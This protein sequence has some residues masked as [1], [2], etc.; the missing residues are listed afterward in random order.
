[1]KNYRLRRVVLAAATLQLCSG[2]SLSSAFAQTAPDAGSL[3]HSFE[4]SVPAPPPVTE[5]PETAPAQAVAPKKEG[6][7]VLVKSFIIEAHQFSDEELQG[8][9]AEY[10]GQNLTL[11]ELQQAARKISEY[12]K[13]Q[14][15]LA[16]AYLPPQTIKDGTVKIIVLEG[17]LG[18]IKIDP[19][20]ESRF[21]NDTAKDIV[22]DRVTTGEILHPDD[23]HEG[24]AVLNEVPGVNATA[25]LEPGAHEG[26]TDAVIKL[27][28]TPVI[29]GGL[30]VDNGGVRS[31][32]SIRGIATGS[33]NDAL[34]YGEQFTAT[35][36]KSAYSDYSRLGASLP[37]GTSGLRTGV[38]ASMMHYGVDHSFSI[39]DQRGYAYTVGGDL[40]YPVLRRPSKSVTANVTFDHKRLVNSVLGLNS[41][42]KQVNVSTM[43]ANG[44]MS[45]NILAGAVNTLNI[46]TTLGGLDLSGNAGNLTQDQASARTNGFYAKFTANGS[47]LQNFDSVNQLYLSVNAQMT[48]NNLDS[49]EQIS[50]GGPDGVRAYPTNEALGDKGVLN[51]VELRHNVL[52]S[53]QLFDF[54]DAG[55][56]Q[57]HQDPWAGWNTGSGQPNDYWLQGAGVGVNWKPIDQ[58]KVSFTVAHTIGINAGQVNGRNVD[59]YDNHLR[60]MLHA[61]LAF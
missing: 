32:G 34:G 18:Q 13:A 52:T 59:G 49:S 35:V 7:R 42:D 60:L 61:N 28:D 29:S 41:S 19:S 14:G 40:S 50:L 56:I 37:V 51:R 45:D 58:G 48:G 43:S 17:N 2:L 3:L 39:A 55:W 9:V 47:R 33:V 20:S 10:I 30:Q 5:N 1:M 36:L 24:V 8:V 38:N 11:A 54:Y 4:K 53:V 44:V 16:R 6:A 25:S 21:D 46:G 15:Y 22:S 23:L 26:E 27:T 57:Q 31:V 12:Y